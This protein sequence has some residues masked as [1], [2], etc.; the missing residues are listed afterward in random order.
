MPVSTISSNRAVT[1]PGAV[2]QVVNATISTFAVTNSTTYVDSGLTAS[3]TPTASSSKILILVSQNGVYKNAAANSNAVNLRLVKNGT[4][5][6][7]FA[8]AAG[9]T[10]SLVDN[11]VC[12]SFN[13]LDS[14]A[15]TSALTYKVQ[16]A[17]FTN[18]GSVFVQANNDISAITL[19]EI[20]A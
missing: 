3:I 4:S 11:I 15:T 5:I 7:V 19:M 10:G 2:L 20:A 13:Y 14:P 12:A 18:S 6:G 17:N 16:F 1:F 8:V 9:Y